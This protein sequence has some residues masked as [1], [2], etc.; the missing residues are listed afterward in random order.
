[1]F[2]LA[3][4]CA[5]ILS[6]FGPPRDEARPS[7]AGDGDGDGVIQSAAS[8]ATAGEG[9]AVAALRRP[10][11]AAP[12]TPRRLAGRGQPAA[13]PAGCLSGRGG[14]WSQAP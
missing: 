10:Q 3:T 7:R 13:L 1:V 4:L 2:R 11:P 8:E 12:P 14:G 5:L 6:V 9:V